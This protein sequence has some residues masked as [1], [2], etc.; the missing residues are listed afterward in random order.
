MTFIKLTSTEGQF[1]YVN[2]Q[3]IV[4][5]YKK[6]GACD[7]GHTRIELP[8]TYIVARETPEEVM[9]LIA[10]NYRI[11]IDTDKIIEKIKEVE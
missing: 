7:L 4:A 5:F 8:D 2:A 3:Q 11:I 1:V 10:Q 6:T 9:E